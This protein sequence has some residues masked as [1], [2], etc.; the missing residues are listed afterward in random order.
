M[1]RTQVLHEMDRN[2]WQFLAITSAT[3]GCGKSITAAN[4]ALGISRLPERSALLLDLDLHKPSIAKYLGINAE[5]GIMDVL[6]G[7]VQLAD[8][9]VGVKVGRSNRRLSVLPGSIC[10]SGASEWMA[11]QTLAALLKTIQRDYRSSIV[12]VDLPPMLISD[13][14][15]SILPR[16]DAALLIASVG[17]TTPTEIQECRK[18]LKSTPVV[19]VV[20]NRAT[21]RTDPYYGYGYGYGYGKPTKK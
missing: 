2:G 18:Y 12:I 6:E 10:D 21:D 19:R 11:S 14:V 16:V 17:V 4:L 8:A 1:L 7:G 15:M 13:E 3:A 9:V 5:A 20:L